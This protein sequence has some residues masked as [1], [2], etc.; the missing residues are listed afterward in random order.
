MVSLV[1]SVIMWHRSLMVSLVK[2]VIMW[3]CSLMVS[4]VIAAFK[5][6][7]FMADLCGSSESGGSFPAPQCPCLATHHSALVI[8]PATHTGP[9]YIRPKQLWSRLATWKILEKLSSEESP[10]GELRSALLAIDGTDFNPP[11][12]LLFTTNQ[13]SYRA[14][15]RFAPSQWETALL[16]NLLGASI[17]SALNYLVSLQSEDIHVKK[18]A[19]VA[20]LRCFPSY[21]IIEI[22]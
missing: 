18:Q 6:G 21:V 19:P 8:L 1:K 5:P 3:H 16:C 4:L 12:A 9:I 13:I 20:Y 15:S 7:R 17:E 22:M 2:S 10:A 11:G 14:D